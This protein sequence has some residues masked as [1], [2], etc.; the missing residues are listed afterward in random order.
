MT[1]VCGRGSAPDPAGEL[2]ALAL[3]QET[4]PTVPALGPY[5]R[6]FLL[7]LFYEAT[8]AENDARKQICG[9]NLCKVQDGETRHFDVHPNGHNSVSRRSR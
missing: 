5:G 1:C 3:P 8:S 9:Q 4:T 2:T 7:F 6:A